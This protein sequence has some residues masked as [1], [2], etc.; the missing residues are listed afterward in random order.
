MKYKVGDIIFPFYNGTH[1]WYKENRYDLVT[2][3]FGDGTIRRRHCFY[4]FDVIR[5][6]QILIRLKV[7]TKKDITKIGEE[8]R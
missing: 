5:L 4:N 8:L 3:V 6:I 7:L 1:V 2:K